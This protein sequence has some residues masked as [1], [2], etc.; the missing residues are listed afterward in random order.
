MATD[1]FRESLKRLGRNG[2]LI[3]P[4]SAQG[5][6]LLKVRRAGGFEIQSEMS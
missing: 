1:S 5:D 4:E 3:K 2:K 6:G